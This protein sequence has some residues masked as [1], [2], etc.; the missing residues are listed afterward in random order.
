M[1]LEAVERADQ[2]LVRDLLKI[3]HR[4]PMAVE[5][6][7]EPDD[8]RPVVLDQDRQRGAVVVARKEFVSPPDVR[9]IGR[10]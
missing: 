3:L 8:E 5:A 4:L 6:I 1:R 9:V 10:R 2:R 7:G